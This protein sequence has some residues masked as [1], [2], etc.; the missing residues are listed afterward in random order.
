MDSYEPA[1]SF[2][3]TTIGEN[4]FQLS[5]AYDYN[6]KDENGDKS[7]TAKFFGDASD[8]YHFTEFDM[9]IDPNTPAGTYPVNFVTSPQMKNGSTYITSDH[10]IPDEE[11]P[12]YYKSVYEQIT[13]LLYPVEIVVTD[14]HPKTEISPVFRYAHDES[15]FAVED[16]PENTEISYGGDIMEFRTDDLLDV[17]EAGRPAD[18]TMDEPVKILRSA[19]SL[20]GLSIQ[21]SLGN[22]AALEYYIGK[23]GDVNLDGT[24]NSSDAALILTYAAGTGSGAGASLT[25]NPDSKEENFAFFLGDI[26]G[27]GAEGSALNS[28]DAAK[29]LVY[30]AH[31]GSG[32][33]IDW[34]SFS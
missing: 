33:E 28:E 29:I 18:V 21:D 11:D 13:P 20:D 16:F 17:F 15:P 27:E 4:T 30:A 26:D 9:Q 7:F 23:K 5:W 14:E 6:G 24:V 8:D 32:A 31:Q 10:S 3:M 34:S 22:P 19:L 12:N 2:C 1:A 25:E